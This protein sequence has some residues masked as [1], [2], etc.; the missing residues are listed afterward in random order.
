[1]RI[2]LILLIVERRGRNYERKGK[3]Y[4]IEVTITWG[5]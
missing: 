1:M 3:K 5:C 4:E 2:Y